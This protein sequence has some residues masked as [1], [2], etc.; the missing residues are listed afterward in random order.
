MGR[1]GQLHWLSSPCIHAGSAV[2][3]R[4]WIRWWRNGCWILFWL[5][6]Y[7]YFL[8]FSNRLHHWPWCAGT[9]RVL[10]SPWIERQRRWSHIPKTPS[11][12]DQARQGSN[13]RDNWLYR[14]R[15][16]QIS[17]CDQFVK[18]LKNH[19]SALNICTIWSH[20]KYHDIFWHRCWLHDMTF[21][22]VSPHLTEIPEVMQYLSRL[23]WDVVRYCEILRGGMWSHSFTISRTLIGYLS[24]SLGLKFSDVPGGLAAIS[25]VPALSLEMENTLGKCILEWHIMTDNDIKW[26]VVTW[27]ML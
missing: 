6:V 3:G 10:G 16:L 11:S 9:P 26:H 18:L 13:V 24:P 22:P 4:C 1:L 2:Q 17:R 21:H 7:V 27:T 20:I 12:W 5:Q 23:F 25:K 14:P 19:M 15:I 8:F